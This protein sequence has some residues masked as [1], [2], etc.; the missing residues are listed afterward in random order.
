M[1][2][3]SL[4]GVACDRA[5][6]WRGTSMGAM[7]ATA[8]QVAARRKSRRLTGERGAGGVVDILFLHSNESVSVAGSRVRGLAS[9]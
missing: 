7:G 3:R 6:T 8:T 9:R 1:V 2:M 4:G 5:T